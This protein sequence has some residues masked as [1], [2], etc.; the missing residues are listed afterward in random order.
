MPVVRVF[1]G[2]ALTIASGLASRN[3][4]FDGNAFYVGYFFKKLNIVA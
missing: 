1:V 3:Y 4:F 2:S